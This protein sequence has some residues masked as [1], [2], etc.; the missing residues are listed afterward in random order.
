MKYKGVVY[1]MYYDIR[2]NDSHRGGFGTPEEAFEWAKKEAH[3]TGF[4][5]VDYWAE[6]EGDETK[7]L[8]FL[9]EPETID[10]SFY[11]YEN[12]RLS[13]ENY[14]TSVYSRLGYE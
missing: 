9:G 10:A 3:A 7:E 6:D 8:G 4:L 13:K 5:Y 1:D 2:R 12:A 11:Q 14:R